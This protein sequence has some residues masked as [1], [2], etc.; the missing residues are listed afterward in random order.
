MPFG[1]SNSRSA[2][3]GDATFVFCSFTF[4]THEPS[5][6]HSAAMFSS[7]SPT[8]CLDAPL[9]PDKAADLNRVSVCPDLA[10]AW[11]FRN[12]DLRSRSEH[13]PLQFQPKPCLTSACC[14]PHLS[15]VFAST[16][17]RRPLSSPMGG[18]GLSFLRL[19]LMRLQKRKSL[20]RA[21]PL[22]C[23]VFW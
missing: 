18:A 14:R 22:A 19:R 20:D 6:V 17:G 16:P 5:A 2:P 3:T 4:S 9:A 8:A 10:D 12:V 7:S 1:I 23:D 13:S 21:V 15:T 11:V